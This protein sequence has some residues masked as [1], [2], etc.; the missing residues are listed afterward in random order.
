M[1]L[2]PDGLVTPLPAPIGPALEPRTVVPWWE[3]LD[4]EGPAWRCAAIAPCGHALERA[5]ATIDV[6][7]AIFMISSCVCG[8][9]NPK[10]IS[11]FPHDFSQE[12]SAA[13][14]S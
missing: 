7:I 14:R 11:A 12:R 6:V 4:T 1:R 8:E 9:T 2:L 13:V 10:A 3:E 5:S